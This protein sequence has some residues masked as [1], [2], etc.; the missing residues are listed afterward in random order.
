MVYRKDCTLS[1]GAKGHPS[2][3]GTW[4]RTA[5]AVKTESINK[6]YKSFN[7]LRLWQKQ[8]GAV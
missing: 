5:G 1:P 7:K 6:Q 2:S 8:V 4:K 3:R